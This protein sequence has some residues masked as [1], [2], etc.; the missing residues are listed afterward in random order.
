MLPALLPYPERKFR[1]APACLYA[2]SGC[3]H[4]RLSLFLQGLPAQRTPSRG[5]P[6]HTCLY[7][8]CFHNCKCRPAVSTLLP[9]SLR[10]GLRPSHHGGP[11]PKISGTAFGRAFPEASLQ[12][13]VCLLP[14]RPLSG[15]HTS[16]KA[17]A[18]RSPAGILSRAPHPAAFVSR[19]VAPAFRCNPPSGAPDM[20]PDSPALPVF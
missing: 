7:R 9:C 12:G 2:S 10:Q 15:C 14:A 18:L 1:A 16:T 11:Y 19:K 4:Y 13:C 8:C 3:G 5:A 20:R 17:E 6:F